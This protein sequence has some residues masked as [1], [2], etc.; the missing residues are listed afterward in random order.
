MKL[1][2]L[3]CASILLSIPSLNAAPA[4]TPITKLATT[5]ADF[6]SGS[7]AGWS[8]EGSAFGPAPATGAY[9]NQ[10]LEGAVGS[11]LANSYGP[12]GDDDKGSLTSPPFVINQKYLTCLLGGGADPEGGTALG[13]YLEVNGQI[14]RKATGANSDT[15]ALRVWDVSD[16]VGKNARIIIMDNAT[17]PYGHIEVDQIVL[18][19][20][21]D[22]LLDRR[23]D[24]TVDLLGFIQTQ[25]DLG[26]KK[27]VVPPGRYRVAPKGKVHLRFSKLTAV[28]VVMRGVEMV[29]TQ[30]TQAVEISDCTNFKISGL[31][32]DYDPL[33]FTQARIT[34]LGPEKEW[35]EFE[36]IEGYPED[37]LQMRIE[38]FDAKTG[39][40]KVGTRYDW[41]PFEKIG[42]R[43]YRVRRGEGYKFNQAAVSEEVGDLLVTNNSFAPGGEIPHTFG[44]SRNTGTVLEDVTVYGSNCMSFLEYNCDITTY[45]RCRLDR[46]SLED[47]PVKRGWMRLRS[48]NA[49]AFHSIA[50]KRGPQIISS[51]A[52]YMGDDGVN[53]RGSYL[54]VASAEGNTIRLLAKNKP[55][56]R[57]GD[58]LE[59]M[60][61]DGVRLPDGVLVGEPE[62]DGKSTPEIAGFFRKQHMNESIQASLSD[63]GHPVW[64][65]TVRKP[66]SLPIGSVV[67]AKNRI[68]SGF[69]VKNSTF[70]PNR[71]RGI[72]I[73]GSNG[74]ISGNTCRGNWGSGIL[75]APEW[76]WLEGGSSDDLVISGN[77]IS[78]CR[79]TSINIVA[80]AGSGK[81]APAGAHNRIAVL[82]NTIQTA[83]LPALRVTSVKD[84]TIRGNTI[85][86][87]I[88]GEATAFGGNENVDIRDNT[89]TQP[90]P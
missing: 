4:D 15:M 31:T 38:I 80:E 75:I 85:T 65:I 50:A 24:G 64:K 72:L 56:F 36:I 49:D 42:N 39:E 16:L 22:F 45:L 10:R 43:K 23:S 13:I 40:L 26:K 74:A 59:L 9:G 21:L 6:E 81:T 84:G 88:A 32:I 63:P 69:V 3:L 17:G 2:P 20:S 60:T 70:G 89:I 58:P 33:P 90:K 1:F 29:C 73:K 46:R 55:D 44:S 27:V 18:T 71:S 79:D 14:V 77:K 67:C 68:G 82:D 54:M 30:T 62:P 87:V 61:Y 34:A 25:L 57:K 51:L 66:V 7:W 8:S 52:S 76:W 53:I 41:Q 12:G 28:E 11:G 35:L 5:I 83:V 19:D 37:Q 47:D 48:G 78:G 86:A